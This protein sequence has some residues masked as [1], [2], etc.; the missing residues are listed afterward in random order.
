MREWGVQCSDAVSQHAFC[1]HISMVTLPRFLFDDEKRKDTSLQNLILT[2]HV[3]SSECTLIHDE[4][5]Y[6]EMKDGL[7]EL[8]P[9]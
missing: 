9:D 8:K 6:V 3:Y 7:G 4:L 5:S 2:I 1:H